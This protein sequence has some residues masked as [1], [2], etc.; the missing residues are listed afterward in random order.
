MSNPF[1]LESKL[2]LVTGA[3]SG[4]GRSVAIES[5]KLGATIVA[6][7]LNA[8]KLSETISLL[9]PGKH[10]QIVA[11]LTKSEDIRTISDS[12]EALDGLVNCAGVGLTLPFKFSGEKELKRV[13]DINFFA[14]FLLTQTLL[15]NRKIKNRSSIIYISSID[16]TVTG[17]IGNSIYSATKGAIM[18]S[19]RSQALELAS[20]GIRVNCVSPAR[21]DTPLIVRDNITEEQVNLNMQLYPLKRYAKPEE[22]AFY[23]I[24]LLSD[25]STYTTGSNLIIDG[26][27]TI[28]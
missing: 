1:S 8:E 27:F 11:D 24:Y 5:S 19:V 25:V 10:I 17:H 26:G 22:I 6:V 14:S 21:V 7:D 4:I 23:I 18:G 20:R 3:A 12:V 15:K 28:Q 13:M 16:G 9:N 2:I